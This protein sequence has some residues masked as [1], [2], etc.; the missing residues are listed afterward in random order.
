MNSLKLK[1]K[2]LL[3]KKVTK[4]FVV[5]IIVSII[6]AS[7]LAVLGNS[8]ARQKIKNAYYGSET[9]EMEK[10]F[11]ASD[12]QTTNYEI[13]DKST[14]VAENNDPQILLSGINDYVD[15]VSVYF[16]TETEK[17]INVELFYAVDERGI[18]PE[19]MLTYKINAGEKKGG[20]PCE[21]F[22]RF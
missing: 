10:E 5:A 2:D 1:M 22:G 9:E 4:K 19:Q 20:P 6:V 3:S 13:K 16:N 14:F 8:E 21:L 7:F 11:Q 17:E 18:V 15:K 12:L